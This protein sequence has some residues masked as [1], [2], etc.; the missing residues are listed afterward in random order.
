M[1]IPSSLL[2]I[3]LP[4]LRWAYLKSVI[5]KAI[6]QGLQRNLQLGS[7]WGTQLKLSQLYVVNDCLNLAIKTLIVVIVR[8]SFA[9]GNK[10]TTIIRATL[11]VLFEIRCFVKLS[12]VAWIEAKNLDHLRD[13]VKY[14]RKINSLQNNRK[15]QQWYTRKF[16]WKIHYL[17]VAFA[18]SFHICELGNVTVASSCLLNSRKC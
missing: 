1:D 12:L 2:R 10:C 3:Q 5:L 9:L 17:T 7:L 15:N 14:K 16:N 4:E 18:L 13:A 11:A 6:A 8:C